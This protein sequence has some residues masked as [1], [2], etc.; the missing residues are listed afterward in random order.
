VFANSGNG[1]GD[2]QAVAVK[3]GG[4]GDVTK[5]N[6][7]WETKDLPYVPTLLFSGGYL[8]GV[9]DKADKAVKDRKLA[10]CFEARTG[11]NVWSEE[12]GGEFSSSPVLINGNVYATNEE[13][14]VY[15]FAAAPTFKLLAKNLLGE[16]V[17]ATP[18]VADNR[19]YFRG[20]T[21]LI[22]IGK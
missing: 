4:K 11:K 17:M 5:T 14:E 3:L 19:L 18:A 16:R 6:L 8:F 9:R 15:V 21:H 1:E 22:C 2:R 13:G 7:A 20:E 12:F 10:V